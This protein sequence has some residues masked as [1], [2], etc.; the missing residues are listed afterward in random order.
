MAEYDKN[1]C[2]TAC[3]GAKKIPDKH[4]ECSGEIGLKM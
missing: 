1:Y 4:P 3:T 2:S